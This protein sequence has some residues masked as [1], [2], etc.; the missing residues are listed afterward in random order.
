MNRVRVKHDNSHDCVDKNAEN[1]TFYETT[2][3][4]AKLQ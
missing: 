4:I 1:Q 3:A 2:I